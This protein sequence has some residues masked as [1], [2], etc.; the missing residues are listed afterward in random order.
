MFV[1]ELVL[2]YHRIQKVDVVFGEVNLELEVVMEAT[3]SETIKHYVETGIGVA[4]VPEM[5]MR[6]GESGRIISIPM[7]HYF[8]KSQY[9][10]ILRKGKHI[11]SWV[12][13]FLVILEPSIKDALGI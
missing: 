9:G 7:D 2:Q 11:T 1:S 13:N 5:T 12:K 10:V 4:I 6:P 3:N 8:G